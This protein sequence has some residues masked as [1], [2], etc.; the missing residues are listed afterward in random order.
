MPKMAISANFSEAHLSDDVNQR[1]DQFVTT[2]LRSIGHPHHPH[3]PISTSQSTESTAMLLLSPSVLKMGLKYINVFEEQQKSMTPSFREEVFHWH[4]GSSSLVVAQMFYDLQQGGFLSPKQ[5][6]L[7]GFKRYMIA[8]FFLWI[9]PKNAGVTSTQFG[10]CQRYC[11]GDPL[12]TWI[13]KIEA[14][15]TNVIMWDDSLGS[16]YK[17]AYAGSVDCT[18]CKMWEKRHHHHLNIDKTFYSKKTNSAALKYEIILDITRPKCLAVV[19]P[20]KASTHD[21]NVFRSST[22]AKM[23]QMPGKMLVAD[24]IYLPGREADQ[25]NEVGMFSIPSSTDHKTLK[26]FK[27][28]IRSRHE[29]FNGRLKNFNFL[30]LGYCGVDEDKHGSAFKAICTIVQY[31][32]DLGSPIFAVN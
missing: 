5:N 16:E 23:L 2:I 25:R 27:S 22:K 18:D 28:R 12:W 17:S 19:G 11:K 24:S 20:L 8:H 6:T 3:P 32:M 21:M 29:T 15:M 4:Y 9:Y 10:V 26:Q 13:R 30:K 7:K 14:L 1:T 31:Q